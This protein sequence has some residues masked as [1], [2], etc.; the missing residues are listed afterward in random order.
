MELVDCGQLQA[1]GITSD[2]TFCGVIRRHNMRRFKV[3]SPS[4][5]LR[6][7]RTCMDQSTPTA[8]WRF[9]PQLQHLM[10]SSCLLIDKSATRRKERYKGRRMETLPE[11][12]IL[13]ASVVFFKVHQDAVF[14]SDIFP[15]QRSSPRTSSAALRIGPFCGTEN[16]F[17]EALRQLLGQP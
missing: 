9:S 15:P 4:A 14:D 13:Q 1:G 16:R 2:D 6:T 17:R 12:S 5:L 8:L 11:L 3:V 7:A 10:R